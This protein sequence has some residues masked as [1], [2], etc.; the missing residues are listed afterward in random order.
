MPIIIVGVIALIVWGAIQSAR[1][2]RELEAWAQ[3]HDWQFSSSRER[4]FDSRYSLF[5]CLRQ[6]SNRYAYNIIRGRR[7]DRGVLGFDYHYETYSTDKDGKRR[8]HHHHFSALLLE[9][10]LPLRQ[11]LIRPEGLFDKLAGFFGFEDI[12]FELDA[13]SRAF[14]VKGPDRQWAYDVIHQETME[15]LLASPR[16]T[17]EFE[18]PLVMVRRGG[19]MN[20]SQYEEALRV[21]G[22]ILDRLPRYVLQ[23]LKVEA[24]S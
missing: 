24:T 18:G 15:F 9:T 5:G 7:E 19:M 2:R 13:F 8:T 17:I 10:N 23:D 1:R 20:P 12:N 11:L 22:G 6:G 21:G 16:F 4:G 14:F 3:Q